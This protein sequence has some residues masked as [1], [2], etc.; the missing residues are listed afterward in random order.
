MS[1]R[2][3][4]DDVLAD[5]VGADLAYAARNMTPEQERIADE[6]LAAHGGDPVAALNAHHLPESTKAE[7]RRVMGYQA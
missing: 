3:A 4:T 7:M 6:V 2:S 5:L 1:N